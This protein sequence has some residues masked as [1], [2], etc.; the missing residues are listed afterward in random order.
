MEHRCIYHEHGALATKCLRCTDEN[1]E[2][3]LIWLCE[4]HYN[5]EVIADYRE[6]WQKVEC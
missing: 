2:I 4:F 6:A 1:G 3:V 5:A